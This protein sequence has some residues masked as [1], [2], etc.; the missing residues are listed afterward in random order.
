MHIRRSGL[1]RHEDFLKLWAGESISVFG[2]LIGGIALSFTAIIWLDASAIEVAVLALCQIVPGFVVGPLAGVWVDRLHRRPIMIVADVGRFL[3]L[4]TIPLAALFDALTIEQLW[5]VATLASALT[6][7]FDVAYQS[8]LPTLV[9]REE[10][11]EGNA[12]LEASASVAEIGGFGISGWLVQLI[13]APGAL[14][15]DA[16]SFLASALFVWRIKSPEPPPPPAHER[17]PMLREAEEGLR[18]LWANSVLRALTLAA[19]LYAV[20]SRLITVVL[21]LYL[22]REL[23]FGAGV[24]GTIFA[25]GGATSIV[26][27]FLASRSRW[28]GGL[29]P[30]LIVAAFLR[31]AGVVF[32]AL[33][34]DNGLASASILVCGQLFD[35]AWTFY[36]IN[37]LSLRQGVTDARL[38]GRVHATTRF[39]E[40]GA[41]VVGTLV[42][43]YL[44]QA[45][46]F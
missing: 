18:F 43:G 2:T 7:F 1:W 6:T 14:L 17:R 13:T 36:N 21:L 39:L 31:S 5:A 45:I 37:E 44:G 28:F 35:S 40:F 9:N 34:W 12:K 27:A 3:S 25:V 19:L 8:Y 20:S 16:L 42:A 24:L 23:G 46:G 38:Q 30:A 32:L 41:M 15:V 10:L 11:V 29:G 4:A 22:N 33:P 26:G